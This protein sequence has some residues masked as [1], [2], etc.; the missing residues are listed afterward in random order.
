MACRQTIA[1]EIKAAGIGGALEL[2]AAKVSV[3]EDGEFRDTGLLAVS[4][5]DAQAVLQLTFIVWGF[6]A[7]GTDGILYSVD[8]AERDGLVGGEQVTVKL[9]D[10]SQAE[11]TV[12]GIFDADVFGNLIVERS[13]FDGQA[14][15][16]FDL[17]V[18]VRSDGGVTSGGTAALR[19]VIDS[20]PTAKLQSREEYIDEQSKQID[21]FLNFI[22]AARNVNLHR[23]HRD[24]DHTLARCLR[25]SSRTRALTGCRYDQ[26]AGA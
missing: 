5:V 22:Y 21:G 8:K 18:F 26:A 12:R 2:S 1:A 10:G 20:Y 16:L 23:R 19:A 3:L 4:A 13:L 15:P 24:C 11:L 7:P 17:A 25:T 9:L 6:E 14:F